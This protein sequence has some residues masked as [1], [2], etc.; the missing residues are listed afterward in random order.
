MGVLRVTLPEIVL[1]FPYN[2]D[3]SGEDVITGSC[4]VVGIV[5][6]AIMIMQFPPS[7][8]DKTAQETGPPE[9]LLFQ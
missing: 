3:Q 6:R 2:V 1:G 7:L 9:L 4:V 8:R 5:E